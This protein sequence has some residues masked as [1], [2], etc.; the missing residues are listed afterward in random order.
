MEIMLHF[1]ERLSQGKRDLA[2]T[3]ERVFPSDVRFGH[4]FLAIRDFQTNAA[5]ETLAANTSSRA[6]IKKALEQLREYCSKRSHFFRRH[7]TIP[8]VISTVIH[9]MSRKLEYSYL[10]TKTTNPGLDT[11]LFMPW[12]FSSCLPLPLP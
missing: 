9:S 6:V 1:A 11:R 7:T 4:V 12:Y 3:S 8:A 2:V 5:G 10:E